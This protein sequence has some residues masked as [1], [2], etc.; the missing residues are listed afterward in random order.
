MYIIADSLKIV[1]PAKRKTVC[2]SETIQLGL[3]P[4]QPLCVRT[5]H[6]IQ[7]QSF[8]VNVLGALSTVTRNF[9][10]TVSRSDNPAL[11]CAIIYL[12]IS[13]FFFFSF[14]CFQE[15]LLLA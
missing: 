12:K 10:E 14:W 4:P 8:L 2:I 11:G 5:Q 7:F 1:C 13:C 15:F 3:P 6:R 9:G